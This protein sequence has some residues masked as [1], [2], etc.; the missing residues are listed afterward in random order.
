VLL[1]KRLGKATGALQ[2][3]PNKRVKIKSHAKLCEKKGY[4]KSMISGDSPKPLLL[5]F[6]LRS[7]KN[8][9]ILQ[10]RN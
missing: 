8:L 6:N 10:K 7:A 9:A 4:V 2:A 5:L 3:S 1:F